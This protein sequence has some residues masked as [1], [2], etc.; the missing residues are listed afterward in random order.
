MREM[1]KP[2]SKYHLLKKVGKFLF[3]A[4]YIWTAPAAG[5]VILAQDIKRKRRRPSVGMAIAASVWLFPALFFGAIIA[6]DYAT[7]RPL[8]LNGQQAIGKIIDIKYRGNPDKVAPYVT[9]EFTPANGKP[10]RDKE[11]YMGRIQQDRKVQVTYL[12]DDPSKHL[13]TED[14]K[15]EKSN[16][17]LLRVLAYCF[18]VI[19]VPFFGFAYHLKRKELKG[20]PTTR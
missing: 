19:S 18:C 17:E 4:L 14:I 13:L 8:E 1:N 16:D 7:L 12:P 10:I 11:K 5:G 15:R 2:K 20:L 9:Y 6:I 3:Y